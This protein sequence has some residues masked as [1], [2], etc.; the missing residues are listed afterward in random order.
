VKGSEA[1]WCEERGEM[2]EA[3]SVGTVLSLERRDVSSEESVA[4]M[5]LDE[6]L[7]WSCCSTAGRRSEKCP[8]DPRSVTG[9]DTGDSSC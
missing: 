4:P 5:P 6:L 1:L 7:L 2:G 3:G 8:K 9:L